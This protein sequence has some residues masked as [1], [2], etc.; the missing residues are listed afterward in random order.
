M[1]DI[2]FT[3]ESPSITQKDIQYPKHLLVVDDDERLRELL[4]KYLQEQGFILTV[5][6]D[7]QEALDFLEEIAFDLIV[8]DVMM[9]GQSG[10]DLCEKLRKTNNLVPILF[11]SAKVELDDRLLGFEMGGDDYLPKPFEPKELL[12]RIH[13]LLRRSS[14]GLPLT[15]KI[16][17]LIEFGPFSFDSSAGQLTNSGNSVPLTEVERKILYL[18]L[19]TPH[20]PHTRDNLAQEV[21][22]C[23]SARSID[24]QIVRLRRKIE[25]DPKFPR[26]LQTIRHK[27]YVFVP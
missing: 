17:K 2:S 9:P 7:A 6:R 5:A 11:L 20:V 10:V 1:A 15:Q 12:L 22:L 21:S 18:L 26:Y 16:N 23:A 3:F 27:G 4:S 19:E 24:V 13:A 25:K 14:P 8:L